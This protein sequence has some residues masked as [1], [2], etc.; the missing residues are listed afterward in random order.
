[1][2]TEMAGETPAL[3]R[4]SWRTDATGGILQAMAPSPQHFDVNLR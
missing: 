3:M 2:P 1:V 4:I